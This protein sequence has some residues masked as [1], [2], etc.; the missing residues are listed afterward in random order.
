MGTILKTAGSPAGTR[1]RRLPRGN[2]GLGRRLVLG[3]VDLL[4]VWQKRLEDRDTLGRMNAARLRDIG[5][6]RSEAL[7]EADKPFW[8]P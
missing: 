7:R 4:I 2:L 8:R 6:S 3:L 1:P 5:L